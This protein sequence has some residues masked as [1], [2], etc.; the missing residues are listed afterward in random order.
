MLCTLP[1]AFHN[2]Q[3]GSYSI[4]ADAETEACG[5]K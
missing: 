2:L 4:L 5:F 3:G 1:I